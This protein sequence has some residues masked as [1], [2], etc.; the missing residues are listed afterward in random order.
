MD[1]N[2]PRVHTKKSSSAPWNNNQEQIELANP[3]D[4]NMKISSW[5]FT[6]S[7]PTPPFY[8]EDMPGIEHISTY[9]STNH[10]HHKE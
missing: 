1:L 9:R 4:Q 10:I 7:K 8:Q 5:D 3:H 2:H 6:F